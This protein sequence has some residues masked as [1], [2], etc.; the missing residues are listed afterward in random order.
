MSS[1]K[2][3]ASCI[4]VAVDIDVD[5]AVVAVVVVA[6]ALAV[7]DVV[8]LRESEQAKTLQ[9]SVLDSEILSSC[10]LTELQTKRNYKIYLY[11]F[12]KWTWKYF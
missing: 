8:A 7:D 4:V 5:G 2:F 3:H 10:C 11:C 1:A 12:W 6:L 9:L